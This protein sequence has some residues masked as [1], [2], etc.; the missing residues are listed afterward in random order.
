MI[1]V[2]KNAKTFIK[3]HAVIFVQEFD[4][5]Y[6]YSLMPDGTRLVPFKAYK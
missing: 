1:K 4:A 6:R 5:D 3:S 2:K